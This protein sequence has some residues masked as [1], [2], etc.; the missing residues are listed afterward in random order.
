MNLPRLLGIDYGLR[1]IGVALTDVD[2]TTAFGYT[3]LDTKVG[4]PLDQ[5]GRIID[6]EMVKGIVLGLP[7]RSDTGE[8]SE[9]AKAVELFAQELRRKFPKLPI[10]MEDER[11]S[12]FAAEESLKAGG[13][14]PGKDSKALVDKT[15]AKILLQD[16]LDRQRPPVEL[17]HSE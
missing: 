10:Y 6:E 11:F 16:Y 13:W 17:P 2:G 15:A 4:R 3:T 9:M 14:V 5:L 8:P 1:R 7:L 12:S